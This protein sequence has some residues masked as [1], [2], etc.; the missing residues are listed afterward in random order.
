[1]TRLRAHYRLRS[2][3]VRV[4]QNPVILSVQ[5]DYDR[6]QIGYARWTDA[7]YIESQAMT[8]NLDRIVTLRGAPPLRQQCAI[9]F[10]EVQ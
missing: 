10:G 3:V 9:G 7:T 2:S 5:R 1:M 8:G 4:A 6:R